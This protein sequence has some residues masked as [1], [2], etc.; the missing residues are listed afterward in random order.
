MAK[1]F[2]ANDKWEDSWFRKLPLRSKVF[3]IFILDR[4]DVAGMWKKD[5][6]FASF[7][8]G[9]TIS[10]DIL[11]D[12]N[13]RIELVNGDKLWVVRF[14]EFQYGFLSHKASPHKP[15]INILKK[16]GLLQRVMKGLTKGSEALKDKEQDKDKDK[17]K[18]QEQVVEDVDRVIGKRFEDFCALYPKPVNVS[19]AYLSFKI[20]V[21]SDKDFS[22]L[23]MA[24]EN[25]KKSKEVKGGYIK[26]ADTWIMEWREWLKVK[27]QKKSILEQYEV[28]K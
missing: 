11:K 4:C 8:I 7:C 28:K 21:K 15:V 2:T 26:N 13:G 9:E 20:H 14:V 3:W 22:S 23:K 5:Y 16:H 17:E 27:T 6:E 18:E 1:R 10:E 12:F 24:L 25:Y 19:V